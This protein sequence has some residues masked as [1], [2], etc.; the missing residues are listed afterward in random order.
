MISGDIAFALSIGLVVFGQLLSAA[1]VLIDKYVVTQ[2]TITRPSVYVFYVGMTSSVALL[3]LPLGVVHTPDS[4]TI[5][6]ALA[7][8][9]VFIVSIRYLFRAL[10]HANATDVVAWL[11]AVSALTTFAF[12][13]L[14]IN[15]TLPKSFPVAMVL[16]ITGMLF[17]GHFRFQARS[18]MQATIAGALFGLSAVLLKMLFSH[19]N[20]IDGFFWSR[21]GNVAGALSLLAFP[22]IREHIFHISRKTTR[23][24]GALIIANRALNGIAFLCILYAIRVGSVSIVN[25]LSSL[26]F[27]FIFLLIFLLA[28]YVPK[29]YEH[30]FRHGHILHKV[31]AMAFISLGFLTLFL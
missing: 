15:E 10:K 11:T 4:T 8:G 2:T 25:S 26:Q 22:S 31:I 18:L 16:F 3:L 12:G 17:V 21:M 23:H 27:V 24:L 6:L 28:K 13:S 20:F 7:I 1:S 30:E 29:L 5:L 9:F 14:I 19:T